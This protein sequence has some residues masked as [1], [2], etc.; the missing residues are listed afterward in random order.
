MVSE[1]GQVDR[2]ADVLSAAVLAGFV[3]TGLMTVVL[4][5]A[6]AVAFTFGSPSP[7]APAL[8][9][10]M[11]GLTNN[12]LTARTQTALPVAVGLHFLSGIA[13]AVVYSLVELRLR[14][15][16]WRRGMVFSLVPWMLSLLVFL[17]AVGGGPLG[18]RLGAGPL[19]IL[20]NLILHLVYGAALGQLYGPRGERSQAEAGRPEDASGALILSRNQRTIALGIVAGLVVGGA[21]GWLGH[22][23]LGLGARPLVALVLGA[24][25][26]STAGALVGSFLGLSPTESS[27]KHGGPTRS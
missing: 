1:S 10:W 2:R 13:T 20:G 19:P 24:I 12:T 6:Y 21:L 5:L 25:S 11:W 16:G 8:L 26:G 18:L 15:P 14:G 9:R 17:P 23:L 7:Q 22:V 3:A 27:T 4:S